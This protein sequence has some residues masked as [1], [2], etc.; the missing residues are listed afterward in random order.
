MHDYDEF[1]RALTG[2]TPRRGPSFLGWVAIALGLVVVAGSAAVGY[3]VVRATAR[4]KHMARELHASA[5]VAAAQM[6]SHLEKSTSVVALDPGH[7]L[8]F[9]Q[10]LQSGDPAQALVQKVVGKSLDLPQ[11]GRSLQEWTRD[12]SRTRSTTVH[13]D[14]GD[15]SIHLSRG[16][17]GGSL[18]LDSKDGRVTFNLTRSNDGGSLTIDS[19]DGHVSFNL[20]RDGDGGKLLVHSDDG[21]DATV[22][23]SVGSNSRSAPSWVPRPDGMPGDARPV[24]SLTTPD[25]S[26][27]AVTWKDDA[28]PGAWISAYR[29]TLEDAGYEV[30][31]EHSRSGPDGEEASL[32]ARRD[33][34]GHTVFVLARRVDGR[35]HQ[36]LG[37]GEGDASSR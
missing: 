17:H 19:D 9:L 23:L 28:A 13:S 35:T 32:W 12:G 10:D 22:E 30:E 18:V 26:L 24:F 29:T 20:I 15:V 33:K 5:P 36:V 8:S 3:G 4:V 7:G 34:D 27:G 37:Y 2:K 1:E 31:V 16:A 11:D 14:D 25:A 6:V 21:T